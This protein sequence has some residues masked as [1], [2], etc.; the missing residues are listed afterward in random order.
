MVKA[1]ASTERAL[2]RVNTADLSDGEIKALLTRPRIDFTSILGVVSARTGPPGGAIEHPAPSASFFAW[3][4]IPA[5]P[6]ARAAGR[7]STPSHGA[8]RC[9][10]HCCPQQACSR[11]VHRAA[12]GLGFTARLVT[13]GAG[14]AHR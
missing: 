12:A 5:A 4:A 1:V 10:S 7:R 8:P 13:L 6:R 11:G 2:K 3:A 9:R 14:D